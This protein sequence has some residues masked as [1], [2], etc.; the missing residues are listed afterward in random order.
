MLFLTPLQRHPS[1]RVAVGLVLTASWGEARVSNRYFGLMHPDHKNVELLCA[2]Q[3]K[4][5]TSLFTQ[6]RQRKKPTWLTR[7]TSCK[8]TGVNSSAHTRTVQMF[9]SLWGLQQGQVGTYCTNNSFVNYQK[10][11]IF[12]SLQKITSQLNFSLPQKAKTTRIRLLFTHC[13]HYE[14]ASF[15]L[16]DLV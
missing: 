8:H 10:N 1:R 9:S 13:G 2:D 6:Q 16:L 4:L 5:I 3:E 12:F 7:N 11:Q 15:L 14:N